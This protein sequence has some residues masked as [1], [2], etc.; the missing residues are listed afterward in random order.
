MAR[1]LILGALTGDYI[2]SVFE[3]KYLIPYDA[4]LPMIG[5]R[6]TDDSVLTVAVMDALR[7]GYRIGDTLRAYW[8]ANPHRGYGRGFSTWAEANSATAYNSYGNG[9]AMRASA[10]G[11]LARTV[12]HALEL[13]RYTAEPTHNHENGI[14]GAQIVALMI[15]LGKTA[16]PLPDALAQVK[17]RFGL[18]EV[19]MDFHRSAKLFIK[20]SVASVELALA[21]L[22]KGQDFEAVIR[23]A[24]YLGGDVDTTAA[25]AG[26]MAEAFNLPPYLPWARQVVKEA[27][28]PWLERLLIQL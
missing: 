19:D 5:S 1:V 3:Q 21:C 6:F 24:I 12:E 10:A 27:P 22:A 16:V 11:W 26:S 18:K 8:K 14:R 17:A 13:G 4:P 23:W 28:T 2:G 7:E 15:Y 9:S 20:D 25:I